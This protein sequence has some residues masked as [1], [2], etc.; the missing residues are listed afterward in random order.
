MSGSTAQTVPISFGSGAFQT[1]ANHLPSG[2]LL[3]VTSP[4][5]EARGWT[6]HALALM[7]DRRVRLLDRVTPNP[8]ISFLDEEA[9]RLPTG[10]GG[11]V[12]VGGGSVIDTGKVMA[13]LAAGP[14][15]PAGERLTLRELLVRGE[16]V[17]FGLPIV[18][19]P[20]TAGSGSEATPTA[21]VWDGQA[22]RKWSLEGP[23]LL[24]GAAIV[25]PE[26]TLSAGE[27]LTVSSGLDALSHGLEALWNRRATYR[28]DALAGN[29]VR[30]ALDTLPKLLDDPGDPALRARMS[31]ASL[32]AGRAIAHT[33]STLAHALSYPLTAH[34]GVPR[35]L[36]CGFTLLEILRMNALNAP[37]RTHE[38]ARLTAH[39]SLA[40]L[41]RK[42]AGLLK[43]VGASRRVLGYGVTPGT[44]P[45]DVFA[46]M[47]SSE[48]AA[49]H[50][51]PVSE[52]DARLILERSLA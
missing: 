29:A 8:E 41:E 28:S 27:E 31:E 33:R 5:A 35:G 48:R 1:L 9:G 17:A 47:V 20:T 21:T 51:P 15:G 36:A 38:I 3:L 22:K 19:V 14:R 25:D 26:L 2:P 49:N 13:A 44:L 23:G 39:P 16:G 46:Q 18:A 40:A 42:L 12:A 45:S 6:A 24:P 30:L 37:E 34:F 10:M 4:G 52:T 11:V 50:S 43:R 7:H 32:L